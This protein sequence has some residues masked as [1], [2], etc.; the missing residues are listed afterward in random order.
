M[1]NVR[2]RIAET[3]PGTRRDPVCEAIEALLHDLQTQ[4]QLPLLKMVSEHSVVL[5]LGDIR[6]EGINDDIAL[7]RLASAMMDDERYSGLLIKVLRD[8][9]QTAAAAEPSQVVAPSRAK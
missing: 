9:M 1:T 5:S 7:V 3:P 8:P 6:A 2:T 4:S